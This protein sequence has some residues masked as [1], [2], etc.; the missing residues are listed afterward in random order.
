MRA[1][2]LAL[3]LGAGALAGLVPATGPARAQDGGAAPAPGAVG[4]IE[5]PSPILTIDQD[6]VYAA[7][8]FGQRV[9]RELEARAA[10]LAAENRRIETDLAAEELAL[11]EVRPTLSAED[12]RARADAFDARVVAIREAQDGKARAL[13]SLR[14]AARE[15]FWNDS[16]PVLGRILAD[17]GAVAILDRRVVFVAANAID[18]TEDVVA[19]LDAALGDGPGLD[20]LPAPGTAGEGGGA[21]GT[22]P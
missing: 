12:F 22:G 14:D 17:R 6:R 10:E 18:I 2:L 13:G 4:R 8:R 21:A 7:S 3:A 16:L 9:T 5:V 20:A 11:T 1:A 15:A 19:A